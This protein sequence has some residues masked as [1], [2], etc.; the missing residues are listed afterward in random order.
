MSSRRVLKVAEAIR[1]VVSMAIL[2]ELRDPRIQDVTVTYV[3]VSPDLRYA[4]VHVSVMGDEAKEQLSLRGLKNSTGFLQQKIAKRV[5]TRY[6]PRINFVLDR[7]VKHSLEVSR[8]LDE[9]L[10][11]DTEDNEPE[12]DEETG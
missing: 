12:N 9:V 1:E 7:G 8:I 10:P 5:D 4:K 3:E 11:K 2:T 6:T